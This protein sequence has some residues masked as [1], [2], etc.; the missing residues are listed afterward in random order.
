MQKIYTLFIAALLSLWCVPATYASNLQYAQNGRLLRALFG[1]EKKPSTQTEKI[2]LD[3]EWLDKPG[4]YGSGNF[5]RKINH[6]RTGRFYK[7]HIPIQCANG[8]P[9]TQEGE[10]CPLVLVFHGGGGD[11]DS[12]RY[13]SGMDNVADKYGFIVAYPGGT[14]DRLFFSDRLLLWNDGRPQKGGSVSKVDDVGFV[15]AVLDDIATFYKIDT[16]RIYACGYSNGAQ[17]TYRLGKR[18]SNRIAAIATVAGQRPAKDV[19]DPPPARPLSIMQFSGVQDPVA[20]YNGGKGPDQAAIEAESPAVKDVIAS[21]VAFN[22]CEGAPL[23]K[24]IGQATMEYYGKCAGKTEV[25]L[26]SLAD[27]GHT[28]PGGKVMPNVEALGLGKMGGVNQDVNASLQM[29]RFFSR[30]SL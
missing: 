14:N 25:I 23:V 2:R 3:V 27:G 29:W 11:P 24:A 5:G 9:G 16:H 13:E 21:W 7:T 1:E 10:A 19:Y 4:L 12:I 18:L 22:H 20:P 6:D 30:H 26:W 28:W 8:I 17:F 15:E